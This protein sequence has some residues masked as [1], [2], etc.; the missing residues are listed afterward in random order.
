M[1]NPAP[2]LEAFK[3]RP[4]K[5]QT[6]GPSSAYRPTSVQLGHRP[7]E[8]RP[9]ERRPNVSKKSSL[10]GT[11]S[12]SRLGMKQA[13]TKK[14]IGLIGNDVLDDW[15]FSSTKDDKGTTEDHIRELDKIW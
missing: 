4:R 8:I 1:K 7:S 2:D 14:A 13:L 3:S 10:P 6:L 15:R 12:Q 5:A 9:S 11:Q